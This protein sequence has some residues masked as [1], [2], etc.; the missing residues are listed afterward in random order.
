[1]AM[2]IVSEPAHAVEVSPQASLLSISGSD[3]QRMM[4]Q[5]APS[6]SASNSDSSLQQLSAYGAE[7]RNPGIEQVTSVSQL[8]DVKPTDW[9]FQALQSLVERYGC[10]VGYPD[11]TFRGN[12]ATTRFEFAA[13][14]NACLDKIQ[15]LIAAATADFVKKEDLEVVKRL[16][17]EFATELAALR[18][19]V[20]SLEVRTATLEKQQFSTTT[21]L[22][23]E[24]IF[25]VAD[26]FGNAAT[27]DGIGR[28]LTTTVAA[29]TAA[30]PNATR[31]VPNTKKDNTNTI[32]GDRVR[33]V[34]NTSFT[35]KDLL[36]TR[37]AASN[38]TPFAT[39]A[40]TGTNNTRLQRFSDE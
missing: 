14:L 13:G 9:A 21:R 5:A 35:G 40:F 18:G 7:G 17:E 12:R 28:L 23:G 6:N 30:N 19:R 34:L 10:I 3:S 39:N 16:Q 26:T 15:E 29:P 22:N 25:A 8:T 32:F 37:L 20:E 4:A 33:L 24:V 31:A 27:V 11:K 36:Y 2:F 1:M 38:I